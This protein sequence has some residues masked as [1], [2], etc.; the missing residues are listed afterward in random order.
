MPL[1]KG[2]KELKSSVRKTYLG[3]KVPK[4]YRKR[5]GKVYDENDIKPLSYSIAKSKNIKIHKK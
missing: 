2:F 3:E 5:Y 1:T 4:K